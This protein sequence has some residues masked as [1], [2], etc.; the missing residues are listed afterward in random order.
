MPL[1]Q[2]LRKLCKQP[3]VE[4]IKTV[5]VLFRV[6]DLATCAVRIVRAGDEPIV[7]GSLVHHSD[8]DWLSHPLVTVR[9][10]PPLNLYR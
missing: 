7:S 2:S 5:F 9:R 6:R 1:V 4:V 10:V 3:L 8:P